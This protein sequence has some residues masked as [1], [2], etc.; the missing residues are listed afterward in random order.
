[1]FLDN[2]CFPLCVKYLSKCFLKNW[3]S[4]RGASTE[5]DEH[6]NQLTHILYY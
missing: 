6:T 4:N 1:M 5:Y 3:N 2:F